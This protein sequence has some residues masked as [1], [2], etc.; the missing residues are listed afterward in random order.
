MAGTRENI[1]G[2]HQSPLAAPVAMARATARDKRDRADGMDDGQEQARQGVSAVG[3]VGDQGGQQDYGEIEVSK[4]E[5]GNADESGHGCMVRG[6]GG[7]V[8]SVIWS[9]G[10]LGGQLKIAS[11][12]ISR[13]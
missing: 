5:G 2:S 4:D 10:E 3:K 7:G 6:E 13:Q 12:A 9:M 1:I 11:T 8:K